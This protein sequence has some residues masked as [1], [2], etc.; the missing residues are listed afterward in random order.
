MAAVPR[1]RVLVVSNDHV[2]SSMAGPGIRYAHFAREL[3]GRFEVT[4]L[5]PNDTDLELDGVTIL[6]S[7]TLSLGAL[8]RLAREHDAVVAQDL[9]PRLMWRLARS[10]TRVVYDLYD[11]Y[12]M[13]NL[14]AFAAAGRTSPDDE[15]E[16][17]MGAL[18]QAIALATG[19]AF[20][21]ASERQRDLWLGALSALE[22]LDFE[23]Y[24]DDEALR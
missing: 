14:G 8:T 22:R 9:S 23:R 13:E 17:R 24:R 19:D 11:P 6:R 12:P 1:K 21:C 2:G 3:A 5:V 15:R 18:L 7:A 16:Y 20:V 10:P 4:L